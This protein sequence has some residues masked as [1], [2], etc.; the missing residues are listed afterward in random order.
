ML[1]CARSQLQPWCAEVSWLSLHQQSQLAHCAGPDAGGGGRDRDRTVRVAHCCA[2][3]VVR[4]L[5]VSKPKGHS[6]AYG[7]DR[8][9]VE[10]RIVFPYEE[11]HQHSRQTVAWLSQAGSSSA[12]QV[13]RR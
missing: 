13:E 1:T 8:K 12:A 3:C 10:Q 6:T 4:G 2:I 7:C 9:D 5:G 11:R